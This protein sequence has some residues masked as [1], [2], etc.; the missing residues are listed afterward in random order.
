ML[1][2]LATDSNKLAGNDNDKKKALCVTASAHKN[3]FK[4]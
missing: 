1:A 3:Y 4:R 2:L